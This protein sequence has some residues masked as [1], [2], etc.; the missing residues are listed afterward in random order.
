V[1]ASLPRKPPL[2]LFVAR[3]APR[4]PSTPHRALARREKRMV[5]VGDLPS[6][7]R[8]PFLKGK[9][10]RLCAPTSRRV[11][12]C[13]ERPQ[14]YMRKGTCSNCRA[15]CRLQRARRATSLRRATPHD[16]RRRSFGVHA[17]CWSRP[18]QDPSLDFFGPRGGWPVGRIPSSAQISREEMP[19][20]WRTPL[21]AAVDT[22]RDPCSSSQDPTAACYRSP[23]RWTRVRILIPPRTCWVRSTV[24]S[25]GA[26]ASARSSRSVAARSSAKMPS[27]RKPHK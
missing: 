1:E 17:R 9:A 25:L 4:P 27:S 18:S 22:R 15:V 21:P 10:L 19:L 12:L 2:H 5:C 20:P 24:I 16:L 7:T 6:A 14:V 26:Q 23:L 11:C 13:P 3:N 8:P